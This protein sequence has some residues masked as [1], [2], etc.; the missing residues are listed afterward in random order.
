MGQ[1]AADAVSIEGPTARSA[2]AGSRTR[3]GRSRARAE[4]RVLN[5]RGRPII[6]DACGES[7][8]GSSISAPRFTGSHRPLCARVAS[9]A[10]D[11]SRR[12]DLSNLLY[13]GHSVTPERR[14]AAFRLTQSHRVGARGA[15]VACSAIAAASNSRRRAA[16]RAVTSASSP[17]RSAWKSSSGWGTAGWRDGEWE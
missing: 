11:A 12:G 15:R 4:G 7:Q 1:I 13:F 2:S 3:E 17:Q 16:R 5:P 14:Q 6:A 10:M 9:F 8:P